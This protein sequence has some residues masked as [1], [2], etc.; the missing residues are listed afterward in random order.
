MA[1]VSG[2]G[3]VTSTGNGEATITALSGTV[4]GAAAARVQQL[5]AGMEVAP[6][7]VA[8]E[9]ADTAR[10]TTT[11]TDANKHVVEGAE[12]EWASADSGVASV[13]ANGLVTAVSNGLTTITATAG[14]ASA[15][16]SVRVESRAGADRMALVA[17]Y[18]AADGENWTNNANWLSDRPLGDWYGVVTDGDGRVIAVDLSENRLAG[19]IPSAL[20]GLTRLATLNLRENDLTGALPPEI[21]NLTRLREID[22]GQADLSGEIPTTLGKLVELRRLNLEY[23]PF[24][25]SI[26]PELGALAKLEFLNLFRNRLSGRL[27][28]ELGQLR[29]LRTMFVDQ[30]D[31]TGSIPPTFVQLRQLETFYGGHNDGL[32][33]PGTADFEALRGEGSRDFRGPRCNDA[34]LAALEDLYEVTGGANWTRSTGWL[35]SGAV[36]EWYGVEAASLGRV[37]VLDLADNELRGQLPS[38]LGAMDRLSVLRLG[39][40]ALSGRMPLPLMD[41]PLEEF[42][43]AGT[44]LCVPAS[45]AFG[46]WFASI[47]VR[48]G[49]RAGCPALADRE[50]LETLFDATGGDDWTRRDE[51]MTDTPL[52]EWHGVT[53]DDEGHVVELALEAN[54]L[55]GRLPGE[56]ARLGA[57]RLLNLA[58]NSL[59]GSIPR[60]WANAATLE[61]LRLDSNLLEGP[62]PSELGALSRLTRLGLFENRLTGTIPRE[63]GSLSRLTQLDLLGNRLEGTIPRELGALSNLETLRISRNRLTGRIPPEL[64]NLSRVEVIWMDANRLEGEI[65][66]ELGNLSSVRF[67]YLGYNNM[68]GSIPPEMGNLP[69]LTDLGLDGLGLTG[70]IP[71]GPSP[72]GS[73]RRDPTATGWRDHRVREESG[74]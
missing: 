68:S 34:D 22:L 51:W 43:Y 19:T 29:S 67:L 74:R 21:G 30:N 52:G 38:S 7:S 10:L 4:S 27:P 65:P 70:T 39:G 61:V 53:T 60:N 5:P 11:V 8:L 57:L 72:K 14:P 42:R 64:G 47:R 31:L 49:P 33:A 32:C 17:L 37:T 18:G 69:S 15:E 25:G 2:T 58:F 63:L 46:R 40:N 1:T 56:L 44:E 55:R 41:L 35:I 36:G 23:V 45:D 20:E 3:L 6:E 48:Q 54:N 28:A 50:I 13:A 9:V 12:V 59:E 26:P 73:F 71:P 16:V 24:T 62:I 66:P